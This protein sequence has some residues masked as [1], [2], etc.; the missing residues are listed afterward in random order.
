MWIGTKS[1]CAIKN[2][3]IRLGSKNSKIAT[4]PLLPNLVARRVGRGEGHHRGAAKSRHGWWRYLPGGCPQVVR[5]GGRA[6]C[7]DVVKDDEW[8]EA[9]GR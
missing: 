9:E 3:T 8:V 2:E 5:A 1:P 4:C 6:E 7:V